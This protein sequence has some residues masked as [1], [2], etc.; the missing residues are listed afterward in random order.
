[1]V[2]RSD[3]LDV[4]KGLCDNKGNTEFLSARKERKAS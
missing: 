1:M 3:V 4:K 2:L